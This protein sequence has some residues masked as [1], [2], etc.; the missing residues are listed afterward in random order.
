M[1]SAGWIVAIYG[2][3][4]AIAAWLLFGGPREENSLALIG[5]MVS[6]VVVLCTIPIALGAPGQSSEG[7]PSEQSIETAKLRDQVRKMTASIEHLEETLV[8]SDDARRVLNRHKERDLLR[9]AIEEDIR[10][11]EYSAA[12][13][14]VR[15]LAERFGYRADAEELREKI[16]TARTRGEH[17]Q[18]REQITKMN[19][20]VAA[21]KWNEA[22]REA[23]RITRVFPESPMVD[24][25][26]H[27]VES[28]KERHKL[29]I[30]RR[31]LEAAQ[32]DRIDDAMDLLH[33]MDH[34]LTEAEAEQF[35][36]VAR[37]VIGKARENL[38]AQFKLAVRDK[39]W[40][41][42][43]VVG[44]R[45]IREFPNSRMATEVRELIDTVRERASAM[46]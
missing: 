19:E 13:V 11:G 5:G 44:E 8:L 2:T 41:D 32:G 45:I 36:E 33:E 18:I 27:R 23:S 30:E 20:L 28:A 10:A 40:D 17:E 42:A 6:A 38:G 1:L 39:S 3:A 16:E 34:L 21:Y 24:G 26:R 7:S 29:E 37:G 15:E 4:F 31:F 43:A 12:M 35:R 14:L 25:L 9:G 22:Q 46:R